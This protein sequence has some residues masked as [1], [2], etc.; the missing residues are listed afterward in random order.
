MPL[1]TLNRA[2]RAP[3]RPRARVYKDTIGWTWSHACGPHPPWVPSGSW[4][5]RGAHR[6]EWAASFEA[7]RWHMRLCR[8]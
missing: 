2:P 8:R 6:H 3:E 5:V 1:A 7:A 4:G